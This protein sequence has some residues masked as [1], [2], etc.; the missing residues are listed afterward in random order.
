MEE[1]IGKKVRMIILLGETTLPINGIIKGIN[2]RWIEIEVSKK[3]R[4]VNADI[5]AYIE[6]E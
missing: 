6:E 1:F 5:V 3:R 4:I 2:G